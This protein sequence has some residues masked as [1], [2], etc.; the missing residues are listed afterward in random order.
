MRWNQDTSGETNDV[1][2]LAD[3]NH[4]PPEVWLI[5]AIVLF[6]GAVAVIGQM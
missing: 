6:F 5:I 2:P 4:K 1:E 3:D